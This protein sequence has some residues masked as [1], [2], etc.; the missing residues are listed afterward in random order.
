MPMNSAI[1]LMG[2]KRKTEKDRVAI[3]IFSGWFLHSRFYL[4]ICNYQV[5]YYHARNSEDFWV[6]F[7]YCTMKLR[8]NPYTNYTKKKQ[9]KVP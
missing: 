1:Y 4:D 7:G 3:P 9:A 8:K 5:C 2:Y 6:T